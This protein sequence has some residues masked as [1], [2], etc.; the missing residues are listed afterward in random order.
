MN[1]SPLAK[2]GVFKHIIMKVMKF[3]G[4][5]MASADTLKQVA[6]IIIKE[7]EQ[8]PVLIVVSACSGVTNM[9]IDVANAAIS[10][11]DSIAEKLDVIRMKHMEI[12]EGLFKHPDELKTEISALLHTLEEFIIG[13]KLIKE[14][15][16]HSYDFI[17]SYGERLSSTIIAAYLNDLKTPAEAVMADTFLIT[18]KEANNADPL[19]SETKRE[20]KPLI[21]GLLREGKTPVITGFLGR[22]TEGKITTLGRGGSDYSASIVG[23]IMDASE[24]QIWTDV[25]GF[26]TTDPRICKSAIPHEIISFKEA[27]E[28]ARF[29]ARVLHPRTMLPALEKKIPVRIKNTFAPD[30]PG[31]M[32]TF[33]EEEVP[34]TIKAITIKKNVDLITIESA[35]MLMQ[36]G[37]LAKIFKVFEEHEMSVDI[38]ATSEITVSISVEGQDLTQVHKDLSKIGHVYIEKDLSILCIVGTGLEDSLADNAK[39]LQAVAECGISARV[40]TQNTTQTNFS[41]IIKDE[42]VIEAANKIHDVLFSHSRT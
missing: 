12:I 27:S 9:L 19:L 8:N 33:N 14:L 11:R 17:S 37:F 31:T 36:H 40:I 6:Q 25:S 3:G 15:S 42:N 10:K 38:V 39:I 2:R 5:S 21:S 22:S 29:G 34:K 7:K 18:N 28:L 30:E 35:E 4:T 26:Y 32:V 13:V 16:P 20:G 23:S 41:L 24:I 1:I